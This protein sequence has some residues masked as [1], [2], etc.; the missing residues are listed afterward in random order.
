[1]VILTFFKVPANQKHRMEPYGFIESYELI[2]IKVEGRIRWVGPFICS[3][4][5]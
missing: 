4:T 1:M 5:P 2:P 3:A